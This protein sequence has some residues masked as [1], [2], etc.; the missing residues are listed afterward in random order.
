MRRC[1]IV[2]AVLLLRTAPASAQITGCNNDSDCVGGSLV[3]DGISMYVDVPM[4]PSFINVDSAGALT[5]EMWIYLI[6]QPGMNQVIAG[7]WGPRRDRDDEWLMFVDDQ[8]SLHFRISNGGSSAG[9]ADNTDATV[10]F[11]TWYNSWVHVAGVWDSGSHRVRLIINGTQVASDTNELYPARSLRK[12]NAYLQLGSF[13]GFSNAGANW[14]LMHGE[15]DEF[16]IWS[17][18]LTPLQ[19]AC[20]R[21][22]HYLGNEANLIAYYS[23]DGGADGTLLCDIGPYA[24]DGTLRNGADVKKSLRTVPQFVLTNIVDTFRLNLFCETDT[25]F[26]FTL[27]DTSTCGSTVSLLVQGAPGITLTP[28]TLTLVPNVVNTVTGS[29]HFTG[30]GL[31][32]GQI[33]VQPQGSCSPILQFPVKINRATPLTLSLGNVI[34]D[35]LRSCQSE[36]EHDTTITFTNTS[37]DSITITGITKTLADFD[38]TYLGWQLPLQL[39]PGESKSIV[40]K[41]KGTV[42]GNYSDV[43]RILSAD[44]CQG[45]G[46]VVLVGN[47][48]QAFSTVDNLDFG[49]VYMCADSAAVGKIISLLSGAAVPISVTSVVAGTPRFI[50]SS[51]L[52][53]QIPFAARRDLFI[54]LKYNAPGVFQDTVTITASYGGCTVLH[55]VYVTARVIAIQFGLTPGAGLNY[56]NLFVGTSTTLQAELHNLGP[57]LRGAFAYLKHGKVFRII[58]PNQFL[59]NSGDSAAIRIVFSPTDMLTYNDTLVVQDTTCYKTIYL[60]LSGVGLG[61]P[62]RLSPGLLDY[63]AVPNCIC[64]PETLT[65]TNTK[66][67]PL[68]MKSAILTGP[69]FSFVPSVSANE[70]IA[71]GVTR[72]YIIQWCPAALADGAYTGNIT[73][74]SDDATTPVL[75]V[76]LAAVR[77]STH[78][79]SPVFTDFGTVEVNTSRTLQIRIQN[80]STFGVCIDSIV[81]PPGYQ[82]VSSVPSIPDTLGISRILTLTVKFSPTLTAPYN[83]LIRMHTSCPCSE[84]E[85][86]AVRG[87]G[88]IVGL[89]FPWSTIVFAE[90]SRCDTVFRKVA[91]ENSGHKPI[92]VDSI[93]IS[94][95]NSAAF[96]WRSLNYPS[97]LPFVLNPLSSDTLE[98]AF[99]PGLSPL[100]FTN[101]VLTI[102]GTTVASTE[103]FVVSLTGSRKSQFTSDAD[104]L[105]FGSVSVRSNAATQRIAW[106]N[107]TLLDTVRIDSIKIVPD[108]DVFKVTAPPLNKA[109][110]TLN[111][112]DTLYVDVDFSPNAAVKYSAKLYVYVERLGKSPCPEV[113]SSIRL[114]GSGFTP[115]VLIDVCFDSAHAALIGT[116]VG[117]GVVI[118]RFVPQ[119]PVEM[120]LFLSYDVWALRL[121][122]VFSD[123]CSSS[124][125]T[126]KPNGAVVDLRTCSR[127]DS[128]TACNL[129]FR[130]LVP[131]VLVAPVNIDSIHFLAAGSQQVL[132]LMGVGCLTPVTISGHCNITQLA[133]GGGLPALAQNAPNPVVDQAQVGYATDEDARVTIKVFDMLGREVLRPVDRFAYHGQ[134]VATFDVRSLAPGMYSYSIEAGM[135]RAS[136]L[137]QVVR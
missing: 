5:V 70:T 10:K 63:G 108:D 133:H 13:N 64:K 75:V 25:A 7:K 119:R 132:Q 34:F 33:I 72:T 59:L 89:S 62:A 66:G 2:F 41:F 38:T 74:T 42:N 100:L 48:K 83:G 96:T 130:A 44:T 22:H 137:M 117:V 102:V 35:T 45:S 23:C 121:E 129:I 40:V 14:K 4:A 71:P 20:G 58:P 79:T 53:I 86:T 126:Y 98:L 27:K 136:R 17:A 110:V 81:P 21:Y 12:T 84:I 111:P 116:Q 8:D 54:Q 131:D 123:S 65:I 87:I 85:T 16:R 78:F 29:L 24:N 114:F 47:V 9:D 80:G 6:P 99:H 134:Y 97:T 120:S 19:L 50:T 26:T 43:L 69:W 95:A 94:G 37:P 52:P 125:I 90:A 31:V 15:L 67:V 105:D 61:G 32:N 56:G 112:G 39:A 109:P 92:T 104:S 18:A 106:G 103:T 127:L 135:Y 28:A 11:S 113:D 101:A 3:L 77:V 128:G 93:V 68:L 30:I 36:L 88:A 124:T 91:L 49:D 82:I 57:T 115:P 60:P 55:K 76:P 46:S 73:F 51:P 122:Q 1:A 118:G 107:S